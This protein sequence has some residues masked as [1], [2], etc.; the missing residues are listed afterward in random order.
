MLTAITEPGEVSRS[1]AYRYLASHTAYGLVRAY[2]WAFW[3]GARGTTVLGK[4]PTY[5]Q[6]A[7]DLGARSLNLPGWVWNTMTSWEKWS[8]N[9]AWLDMAIRR[10]D[11]FVLSTPPWRASG[12]FAMELSYLR[13]LGYVAR[14]IN[15]Q[16]RMVRP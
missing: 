15:G 2:A 14:F 9:K 13:S 10:G 5:L 1:Y 3:R 11:S 16:W 12:Y 7:R 8:V 6:V 4:Y